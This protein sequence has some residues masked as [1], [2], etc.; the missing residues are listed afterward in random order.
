[1]NIATQLDPEILEAVLTA[2]DWRWL[3]DQEGVYRIDM[4]AGDKFGGLRTRYEFWLQGER[5]DVL[6]MRLRAL[7]DFAGVPE[8]LLWTCNRWNGERTLPSAALVVNEEADSHL[9]LDYAI[10]C[11]GEPITRVLLEYWVGLFRDLCTQFLVEN[12]EALL[13][14]PR[15]GPVTST[16]TIH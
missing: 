14:A 8:P 11:R 3:R 4:A 1:M 13:S 16:T 15:V 10:P 5:N 9:A 6:V 12:A 2:M 7:D